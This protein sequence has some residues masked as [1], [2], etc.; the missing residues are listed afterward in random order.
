MKNTMTYKGYAGTVEYSE[1]DAVL[2]GRIAGIDD[3]I[4]YEGE[5][6]GELRQA[7]QEAVD[8][9]LSHCEATGKTPNRP[10]SGKFTLR[11]DPA[12][13]ARLAARAQAM[14]KSLNQYAADLLAQS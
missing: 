14:G 4:S 5:S 12:L 2:F 13:H 8:D 1:S 6:V 3:I 7:F 9:Y 10:Y 11:I